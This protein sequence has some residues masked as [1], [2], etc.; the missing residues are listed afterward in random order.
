MADLAEIKG[1]LE[2]MRDVLSHDLIPPGKWD[3][4]SWLAGYR[5]ACSEAV[6]AVEQAAHRHYATREETDRA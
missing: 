6:D 4:D 5:A 2:W 1:G 3:A